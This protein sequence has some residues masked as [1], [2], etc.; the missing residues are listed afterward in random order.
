MANVIKRGETTMTRQVK[1]ATVNGITLKYLQWGEGNSK[2]IMLVHGWT[3]F[4]EMWDNFAPLLVD[5]DFDVIALDLRGH[6]DSDKPEGEYSPEVFSKDLYELVRTVGWEKNFALLGQ[7]MGGYIVLDYALRYPESVLKL[8]PANTS[9]YLG[10]NLF[11]RITWK[12]IIAMYR[13]NPAKM[14]P[15]ML[16]KFFQYPV[17]QETID[18]FSSMSLKTAK[19]AGLSA[20]NHCLKQNFEPQL[21]Q[22][23]VPTLVIS[24]EFDQKEL[25]QATLHI[26]KS[27]PGSKL[28]DIRKTGHLPFMEN[29]ADFLK[30]IVDFV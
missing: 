3:G 5:N 24:S 27:I 18:Y 1:S 12:I 28:A 11:S 4:K 20:I 17:P 22:I 21:S 16:P 23:K 6:G 13:K 29:P 9:A 30:A 26:H 8:I 19:H 15:K 14:M 7:S 25:R 2:K 10:R